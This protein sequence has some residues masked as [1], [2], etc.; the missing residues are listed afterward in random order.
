M[1]AQN[2][3]LGE[4]LLGAIVAAVAIGFLTFAISRA[5]GGDS[6]SGY[7]LTARFDRIDGI[8]SG[9][10]VRLSGVKV[11]AVSGVAVDPET[12]LAKVDF[13]VARDVKIPDDSAARVTS[14]GLL[15]G[16]YLALEPGGSV[17]ML[18]P[19]GEVVNTQGSIDLLTLFAS[20]AQ[21]GGGGSAEEPQETTP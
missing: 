8:A 6:A 3:N 2:G 15:G 20:F 10:D 14:D 1:S 4:T 7:A 11:G 5:G 13:T 21:G 19:G 17:D 9:S 16:A 18:P 12:Y